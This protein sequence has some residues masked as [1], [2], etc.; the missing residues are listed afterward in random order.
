MKNGVHVGDYIC[1]YN[2]LLTLVVRHIVK[3]NAKWK[4]TR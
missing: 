3:L 1:C 4:L 2:Y